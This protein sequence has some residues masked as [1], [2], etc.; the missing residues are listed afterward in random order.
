MCVSSCTIHLACF[1]F[2]ISQRAPELR[3]ALSSA[4]HPL[5]LWED[6]YFVVGTVG[7]LVAPRFDLFSR[8]IL[9]VEC[10]RRIKRQT[11][12]LVETGSVSAREKTTN[13]PLE[14]IVSE[15]ICDVRT[16]SE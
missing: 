2:S 14:G 11:G 1:F 6:C 3:N 4:I 15:K 10:S 9:C 13:D 5:L 7:E 8:E 16:C 12:T